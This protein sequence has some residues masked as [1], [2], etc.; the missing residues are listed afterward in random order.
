MKGEKSRRLDVTSLDIDI[1]QSHSPVHL[2]AIDR[3]V[4]VVDTWA[5]LR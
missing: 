3:E 1:E 2:L 4:V 5:R